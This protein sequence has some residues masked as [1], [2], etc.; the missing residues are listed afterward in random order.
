MSRGGTPARIVRCGSRWSS[1]MKALPACL[2]LG[3]LVF[4]KVSSRKIQ[5]G[6]LESDS[7][8]TSEKNDLVLH[9][10]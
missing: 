8:T 5:P 6:V 9:G 10:F 4:E 7:E 3:P 2:Q 1:A